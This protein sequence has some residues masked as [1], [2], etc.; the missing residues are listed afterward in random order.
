VSGPEPAFRSQDIL[1]FWFGPDPL[2]A[3]QLPHKLRLWFGGEDPPEVVALRDEI[4]ANRFGPAVEAAARGE[5]DGWAASPH[6]LLA[7]I[8][9]LDQFPRHVYRG[10]SRAFSQDKRAAALCLAGLE[11]GADGA[12]SPIERMFFYLPLQHAESTAVQDES[13][14]AYRRLAL[15]APDAHKDLFEGSLRFAER[16]RE[17]VERFGRFPHR[18]AALGRLSTA[19][20][21]AW[22]NGGGSVTADRG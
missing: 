21:L 8:I 14:A 3:G 13:I 16:H 11:T 6:R 2:G 10:T 17:V 19:A 4:I 1:D 9:L 5:L 20:E 7:L 12:L 18:N 22:L 15:D